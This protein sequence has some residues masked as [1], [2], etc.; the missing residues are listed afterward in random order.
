MDKTVLVVDDE[1]SIRDS[2][3]ALFR[4]A[5]F[6][7]HT[8]GDALEAQQVLR[9]K[10]VSVA[11]LDL[12]LPGKNGIELCRD[13][14]RHNPMACCFAVTGHKS[15]FELVDCRE[16]GFEDYFTKPTSSALLIQAAERAFERLERWKTL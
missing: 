2:Y 10:N 15:L 4:K 16:A 5:G 9:D 12:N 14:R 6:L 1:E 3:T 13:I 11:F 8:A 7:V